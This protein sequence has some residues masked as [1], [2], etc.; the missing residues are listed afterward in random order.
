L[1]IIVFLSIQ[2][3]VQCV[4]RST[5]QF[6]LILHWV[7]FIQYRIRKWCVPNHIISF[8]YLTWQPY[9]YTFKFLFA[10]PSETE[11]RLG[12]YMEIPQNPLF[13]IKKGMETLTRKIK[14]KTCAVVRLPLW[15]NCVFQ[16][17]ANTRNIIHATYI[18]D[19]VA[20]VTYTSTSNAATYYI[21]LTLLTRYIFGTF[22]F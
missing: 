5:S 7:H 16:S 22:Y 1:I 21:I 14:A 6:L 12:K 3:K 9:N 11:E 10:C 13:L 4:K 8:F 17:R 15:P 19:N 18:K 20:A 2:T